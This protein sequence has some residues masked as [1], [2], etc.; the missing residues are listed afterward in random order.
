M[1]TNELTEAFENFKIAVDQLE[2][3]FQH[4]QSMLCM[5]KHKKANLSELCDCMSSL[6]RD[7]ESCIQDGLEIFE[8]EDEENHG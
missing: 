1:E 4:L 3:E 6:I 2:S 5:K 8:S 7:L